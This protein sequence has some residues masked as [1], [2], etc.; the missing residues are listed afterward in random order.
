[1]HKVTAGGLHV[2][3]L[4]VCA[5]R[6]DQSLR[7]FQ[8]QIAEG[9]G[10]PI[11]EISARRR[12]VLESDFEEWLLARRRPAPALAAP[13][14][15]PG[16][17]R[18]NERTSTLLGQPMVGVPTASEHQGPAQVPELAVREASGRHAKGLRT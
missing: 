5:E 15:G 9:K 7:T 4:S 12:G 1:M 11:V 13:R 17:P 18:K 16:R 14:R 3:G 8:R 6:A 10:P 2:L